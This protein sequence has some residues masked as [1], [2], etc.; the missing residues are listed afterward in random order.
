MS[1]FMSFSPTVVSFPVVLGDF[2][3]DVTCQACLENSP[4]LLNSGSANWPGYEVAPTGTVRTHNGPLSSWLDR[5]LLPV[6]SKIMVR[7]PVKPAESSGSCSTALIGCLFN[8]EDHFHFHIFLIRSS[9][10]DSFPIFPF[11][12]CILT[13]CLSLSC[14]QLNSFCI[15]LS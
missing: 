8:C 9:K 4:P 1:H 3:C 12:L 6:I 10:Y 14:L 5:A 7:F 15:A 11:I 2:G 13:D